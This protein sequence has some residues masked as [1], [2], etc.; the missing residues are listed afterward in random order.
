MINNE[1]KKSYAF[2]PKHSKIKTK[3]NDSE[4][5]KDI[6]KEKIEK[7]ITK[8]PYKDNKKDKEKQKKK[9]LSS[10]QKNK[11]PNSKVNSSKK[12]S[13]KKTFYL[14]INENKPELT[15]NK[16]NRNN[17]SLNN[18]NNSR[19]KSSSKKQPEIKFQPRKKKNLNLNSSNS[20][21][22]RKF[23][24]DENLT[25]SSTQSSK[26]LKTFHMKK[27]FYIP[28]VSACLII[29]NKKNLENSFSSH[30]SS[31]SGKGS[32][33][34]I[35][36]RRSKLIERS[37]SEIN[38]S[39]DNKSTINDGFNYEKILDDLN[40]ISNNLNVGKKNNYCN[41]KTKRILSHKTFFK[42]SNK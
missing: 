19:N 29:D 27:D 15:N 20:N 10:E 8:I 4:I 23:S 26:Q 38:E 35:K 11:K 6:M 7:N 9:V 31:Y 16:K 5:C 32:L 24:V 34:F 14:N 22:K 12:E 37:K 39:Y 33:K 42:G 3:H 36:R 30:S 41:L 25:N 2:K 18:N 28:T 17:N 1:N 21:L 40:L 13:S